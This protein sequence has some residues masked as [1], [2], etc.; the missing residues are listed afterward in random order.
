MGRVFFEGN[1]KMQDDFAA[2]AMELSLG[3]N[4]ISTADIAKF[5]GT[6]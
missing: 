4:D 5:L 2:L 3:F 6:Y 1:E